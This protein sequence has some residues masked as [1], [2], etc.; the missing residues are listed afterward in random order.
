VLDIHNFRG[1]LLAAERK[2][3]I[4]VRALEGLGLKVD[5]VSSGLEAARPKNVAYF[6][7]L[8]ISYFAGLLGDLTNRF[9]GQK[10]FRRR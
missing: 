2:R 5:P 3:V 6:Y 8:L 9:V 1:R 7:A 10:G 4:G